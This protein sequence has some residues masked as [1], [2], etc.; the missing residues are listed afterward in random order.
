MVTIA[1]S[2]GPR[3]MRSGVVAAMTLS[4]A[5]RATT[6]YSVI[7]LAL[8]LISYGG[9]DIM[10]GGDGN[11]IMYGQGG[12]DRMYGERG[13]DAMYGQNGHD[14]LNGGSHVR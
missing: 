11:D 12:N 2:V 4:K 7:T 13:R 3:T 14:Y 10:Q 5:I 8:D 9:N 1:Y 6:S